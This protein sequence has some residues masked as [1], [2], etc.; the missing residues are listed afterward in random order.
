MNETP[1]RDPQFIADLRRFFDLG[2][3]ALDKG[4]T[5]A[6]VRLTDQGPRDAAGSDKDKDAS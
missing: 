2:R 5:D 1:Q 4:A 6:S 3:A